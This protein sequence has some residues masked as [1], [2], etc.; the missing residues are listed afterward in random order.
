M[1]DKKWDKDKNT[2]VTINVDHDVGAYSLG[3]ALG[4][5]KAADLYMAV[6]KLVEQL[7]QMGA[8]AFKNIFSSDGSSDKCKG[9]VKYEIE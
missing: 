6:S 4:E 7:I 1:H 5:M 8:V 3:N 2:F 9:G